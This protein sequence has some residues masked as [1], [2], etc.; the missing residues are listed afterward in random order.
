M[1]SSAHVTDTIVLD[2]QQ[3]SSQRP[4]WNS[5]VVSTDWK[6]PD[7][8][9]RG[10]SKQHRVLAL[11][12]FLPRHRHSKGERPLS[13]VRNSPKGATSQS[14]K[15]AFNLIQLALFRRK[16]KYQKHGQICL[17]ECKNTSNVDLCKIFD[18]SLASHQKARSDPLVL[19]AI[20]EMQKV[21]KIAEIH[22]WPK[23]IS[24]KK[25]PKNDPKQP[26]NDPKLPK[27]A[28]K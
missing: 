16:G 21:I 20:T 11:A 26:K 14:L 9:E 15:G 13:L 23:K 5:S 10:E 12:C 17:T 28:Q 18:Q 6:Q 4:D 19:I 25:W 2:G 22:F 7:K 1:L 27:M 3:G 24:T 8:K